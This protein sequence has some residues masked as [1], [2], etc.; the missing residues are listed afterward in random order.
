MTFDI[1]A[2]LSE[3]F[4]EVL[5]LPEDEDVSEFR[6]IVQDKWDSLA[7]LMILTAVENQFGVTFSAQEQELMSSF[8]TI[9]LMVEEKI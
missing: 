4:R 2:T 1:E 9:K 3:V 5:E 8:Q 6:M 7:Q